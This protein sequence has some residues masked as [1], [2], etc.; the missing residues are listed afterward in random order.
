M[1]NSSCAVSEDVPRRWVHAFAEVSSEFETGKLLEDV[2]SHYGLKGY[3]LINVPTETSS[4][5]SSSVVIPPAMFPGEGF[6]ETG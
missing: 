6:S 4:D 1:T 3:L 5:F 2:V